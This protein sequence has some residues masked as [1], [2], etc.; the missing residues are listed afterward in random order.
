MVYHQNNPIS[1]EERRYPTEDSQYIP[2]NASCL[3][4]KLVV[5]KIG[6]QVMLNK[7]LDL[8]RGLSNGSRGVVTSFS[9]LGFPMVQFLAS[10]EKE[11]EVRIN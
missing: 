5:L 10:E 4:P 6:A 11:L 2:D 9:K 7:N 8:S 3:A 1:A